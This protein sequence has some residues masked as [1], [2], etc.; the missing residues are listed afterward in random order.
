MS[1]FFS[2][3]PENEFVLYDSTQSTTPKKIA[4]N[5][6]RWIYFVSKATRQACTLG[7]AFPDPVLEHAL[8]GLGALV[9]K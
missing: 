6:D 3:L 2:V 9:S 4:L 7:Y 8:N 5:V 1:F